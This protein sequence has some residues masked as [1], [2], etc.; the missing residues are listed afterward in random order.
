MSE[1]EF[2]QKVSLTLYSDRHTTSNYRPSGIFFNI[3]FLTKTWLC[4]YVGTK[5]SKNFRNGSATSICRVVLSGL[6]L[7]FASVTFIVGSF[8]SRINTWLF[9]L[10]SGLSY[11]VLGRLGLGFRSIQ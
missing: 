9:L 1:V 10:G 8:C 6:F 3:V 7:S 2:L 4:I 5:V 11:R